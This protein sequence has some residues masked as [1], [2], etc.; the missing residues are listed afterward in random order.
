MEAVRGGGGAVILSVSRAV[1]L[2]I[3][4]E[5][6]AY[7]ERVRAGHGLHVTV[8][9]DDAIPPGEHRTERTETR[10][11]D[12]GSPE[13]L[14][15]LSYAADPID[16]TVIDDEFDEVE[17]LDED[18]EE[19]EDEESEGDAIPRTE[20]VREE[21][22][23]GE[24]R[25]RGRGR[26]RGRRR[27]G[28]RRGEE[29]TERPAA[30][31]EAVAVASPVHADDDGEDGSDEGGR[32]KRRRR[33]RR[34]GR[35]IREDVRRDDPYAW[36]RPRVPEGDPYVWM[37]AGQPPAPR[38]E[39]EP[40][41]A[42]R[43][44]SVIEREP[45]APVADLAAPAAMVATDDET[46]DIWVELPAAAEQKAKPARSR[47]SRS[48][49]A[50]EAEVPEAEV[51]VDAEVTEAVVEAVTPEPAPAQPAP[52]PEPVAAEAPAAPTPKPKAAAKPALVPALDVAEISSPP[53]KPKRGWWRRG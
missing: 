47:R 13:S 35:R 51:E 11:H 36:T 20:T 32:G 28:G 38:P 29:G 50:V 33:G 37:E 19:I 43:P 21:S 4:N 48:K 8:L 9:I 18:E 25:D 52:E 22:E 46:L 6:R 30:S 42:P 1:G 44:A 2:Y 27:R 53:E 5:K 12:R 14:A 49:K 41:Q 40:E 23:E 16:D 45:A 15:A 31:A 7:L 24:G 26:G 10:E 34:G 39:P 17:D 3:L